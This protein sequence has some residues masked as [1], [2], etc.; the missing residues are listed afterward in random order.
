MY[1]VLV[2]HFDLIGVKPQFCFYR[3]RNNVAAITF[4][5]IHLLDGGGKS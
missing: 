2:V 1:E 5:F 4:V 3:T